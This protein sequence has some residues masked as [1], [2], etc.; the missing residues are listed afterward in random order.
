MQSVHPPATTPPSLRCDFVGTVA[1]AVA[2]HGSITTIPA[3]MNAA[4]SLD[5]TVKPREAAIAAM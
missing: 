1:Q 3:A 2:F 4:A 5:A